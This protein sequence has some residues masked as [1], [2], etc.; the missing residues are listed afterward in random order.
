[1]F[2]V[3]PAPL[4]A[5]NEAGQWRAAVSPGMELFKLG[6]FDGAKQ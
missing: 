4:A 6:G 3:Q 2:T 1:M 5:R